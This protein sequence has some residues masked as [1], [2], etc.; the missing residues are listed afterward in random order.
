MDAVE[1][2]QASLAPPARSADAACVG[3]VLF[4]H[5]PMASAFQAMAHHVDAEL[6]SALIAFD[7]R[8]DSSR[9]MAAV[10]A[11][12]RLGTR[13]WQQV[14]VMVD[15]LG[16]GPWRV[17]ERM[18]A[19]RPM[20]NRAVTGVNGPMLLAVLSL[21]RQG[22]TTSLEAVAQQALAVGHQGVRLARRDD[23]CLW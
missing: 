17:A 10:N 11:S 2:V 8:G 23:R 14:L 4:A 12:L 22:R 16:A 19:L 21:L 20:S 5:A 13:G 6:V 9:E 3:V 1:L 7:V 15:M 18:L